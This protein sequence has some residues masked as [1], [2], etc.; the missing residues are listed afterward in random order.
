MRFWLSAILAFL[1]AAASAQPAVSDGHFV[2]IKPATGSKDSRA[3]TS[4]Q[5]EQRQQATRETVA[6]GGGLHV[7]IY[8]PG[9]KQPE[10][11]FAFAFANRRAAPVIV[12]VHGGGWIKGKRDKVYG[13]PQYASDRGYILVSTDYRPVPKTTIDG[14]IQDVTGAIRWVR[15]NIDR[16]GG[17]PSR[18]VIMGHSAGSH[19]VSMVAVRKA[20]GPLRGVIANDVQAYDLVAYHALR[21]NSMAWV[22]QQAFGP[23]PD[24][25]VKYSPITYVRE[26]RGYPPFL[27]LY[28]QSNYERRKTISR[29]FATEL[30]RRG[31]RVALFDGRGYT[32]GTI[33]SSIGRSRGV[34]AAIDRFLRVAFR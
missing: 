7:D 17:D 26:G 30:R 34:T 4:G 25:W 24:K 33:A 27:I 11:L 5:A 32:H 18:I 10:N 19:L 8:K 28:S 21:D 12:Y 3:A 15:A 23:N 16:Y 22:Y 31:T 20:G 29:A 13:L 9:K 6:I 14:Q 1:L 2:T